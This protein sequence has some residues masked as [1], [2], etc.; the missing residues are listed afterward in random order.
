MFEVGLV[1]TIILDA[2]SSASVL[3]KPSLSAPDSPASISQRISD[4]FQSAGDSKRDEITSKLLINGRQALFQYEDY[5][6]PELYSVE[7]NYTKGQADTPLLK[8]LKEN[9]YENLKTALESIQPALFALIKQE[10]NKDSS[11]FG[12][13]ERRF[14]EYGT[15]YTTS[16][17]SFVL[18]FVLQL[19]FD[20]VKDDCE[21]TRIVFSKL[22]ECVTNEGIQGTKKFE[23]YIA[24]D[25]LD[26]QLND[27]QSLLFLT[28]QM[29]YNEEVKR[30]FSEHDIPNKNNLYNLVAQ[31]NANSGWNATIE[32]ELVRNKIAKN[33]YRDIYAAIS[34]K[35]QQSTVVEPSNG[36]ISNEPQQSTVVEPSNSVISR[37]P[38][39]SNV[40]ER[41][42]SLISSK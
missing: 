39:K 40:V 12:A 15:Q 23:E 32:L 27:N 42:H 29:Y 19:L 17:S 28:L 34:K 24:K 33:K 41:S 1:F 18:S 38:Q 35:L 2:Q 14:A 6:A 36:L 20:G 21:E 3:K 9:V 25:D 30:L 10:K 37:K 13:I 31:N 8:L 26:D 5:V 11:H 16:S 22:F 7:K 4:Y